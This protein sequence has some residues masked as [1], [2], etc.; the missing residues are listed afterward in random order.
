MNH[1]AYIEWTAITLHI[2]RRKILMYLPSFI[3][4]TAAPLSFKKHNVFLFYELSIL[5]YWSEKGKLRMLVGNYTFLVWKLDFFN[6]WNV[7]LCYQEIISGY[8]KCAK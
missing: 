3:E 4:V 6:W 2:L 8:P 1:N 5:R 7:L